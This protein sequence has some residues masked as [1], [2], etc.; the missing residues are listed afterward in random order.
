MLRQRI[1][2]ALIMVGLF[3]AAIAYLPLP[4]LALLLSPASGVRGVGMVTECPVGN[5][6]LL[7]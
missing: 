3:F 4:L 7:G 2:T 6:L 1:F 5:S